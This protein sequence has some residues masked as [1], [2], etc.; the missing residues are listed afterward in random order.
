MSKG[1]HE[2]AEH[3][4]AMR[5]GADEAEHEVALVGI[6][7]SSPALALHNIDAVLAAIG[8]VDKYGYLHTHCN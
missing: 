8:L 4:L 6:D 7:T 3:L 5:I 2:A 1:L